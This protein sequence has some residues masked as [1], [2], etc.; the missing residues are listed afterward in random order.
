MNGLTVSPQPP[1]PPMLRSRR[2]RLPRPPRSGAVRQCSRSPSPRRSP[3]RPLSRSP[4][5]SPSPRCCRRTGRSGSVRRPCRSVPSCWWPRSC[6]W[7]GASTRCWS[8]STSSTSSSTT[9]R[10]STGPRRSPSGSGHCW[11]SSHSS[12]LSSRA[13]GLA[14]RP[15]PSCCCSALWCCPWPP[16]PLGPTT[17]APS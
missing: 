4:R 1:F 10:P 14:P 17:A 7:A 11:P 2:F 16:P 6:C 13:A 5:R 9:P 12:R 15:R 3:S 8:R